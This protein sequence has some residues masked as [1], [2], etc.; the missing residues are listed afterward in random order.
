MEYDLIERGLRLRDLG[1]PRFTWHDLAVIVKH[2]PR[3]S[4]LVRELDGDDHIWGL[5]EQL[6]AAAVDE[7]R[8]A[9]WQ[10]GPAKKKDRPKPI[11]RPGVEQNKTF[12]KDAVSMVEMADWLGWEQ[13][14]ATPEPVIA[15]DKTGQLP[16]KRDSRG[17]FTKN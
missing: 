10:R 15:V 6:L 1:T 17:R 2:L 3:T 7:L 14:F 16:R 5:T 13:Q 12:G 4:A 9:N 11:P 8:G